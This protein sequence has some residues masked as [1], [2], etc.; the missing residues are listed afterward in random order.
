VNGDNQGWE[1]GGRRPLRLVVRCACG[2]RG[3]AAPGTRWL[4]PDCGRAF[5]TSAVP[6]D[7]YRS[8]TRAVRRAKWLALSGLLVIAAIFA[9]LIVFVNRSLLVPALVV[10]GVLYFW[11]LPSHR[12]RLRRLYSSLPQWQ[13]AETPSAV[14]PTDSP[15]ESDEEPAAARGPARGRRG[16]PG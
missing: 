2:A 10:L 5:D 16:R 3:N 15:A 9:P 12:K 6:A 1:H 11:F 13:I 4:C 14:R 8:F 7:E